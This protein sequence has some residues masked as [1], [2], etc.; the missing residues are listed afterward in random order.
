MIFT[1][2]H[3]HFASIHFPLAREDIS[4]VPDVPEDSVLQSTSLLRGKTGFLPVLRWHGIAS[5]HFPLAREDNLFPVKSSIRFTL[6]S[7]SL[8]RGKT[9]VRRSLRPPLESFNPLPSCEG[10]RT[11][12]KSSGRRRD[13]S[14]HFPLARED[15]IAVFASVILNA[16]IH[17]PLAR[18]DHPGADRA[19]AG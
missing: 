5:I 1:V 16:S 19:A 3:H 8:L 18:E 9:R 10:R 2:L 15:L 12:G 14:I 4:Y 13:A 17:F 7:T 11:C 6:Q